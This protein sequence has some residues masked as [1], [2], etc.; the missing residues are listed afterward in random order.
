MPRLPA[1]GKRSARTVQLSNFSLREFNLAKRYLVGVSGGRD[2]VAL[3]HWLLE[4]GYRNLV[5]CHLNHQM[6]GRSSAADA[7]FVKQLAAKYDLDIEIG[8]ADVGTLAGKNKMSIET[9]A[10][11]ARFSFFAKVAKRKR[12]HTIF[13][14]HQAD[15]Q[16]E[17]FLMN[18]FRG[19]GTVGLGSMRE[20]TA[21]CID[22]VDLTI[23]RPLLSLW[24]KE[25]DAYLWTHHL[26]FREDASNRDLS[27]LRNRL[28]HRIIPYLEKTVG[29]NIRPSIWRTAMIMAEEENFFEELM[30][31]ELTELAVAEMRAMP[32]TMQRRTLREW[33]HSHEVPDVSFALI[34]RVR[35]LLDLMT[36]VAKT[37]LPGNRHA[38]RRAGK[39]FIE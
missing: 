37:N 22:E 5:I 33:L 21:R 38:R 14:A 29:R 10:R 13:L 3:L 28:R 34:E 17:T 4:R 24:R 27:A 31:R 36:G 39:I 7:R 9:A 8:S 26:K 30:P 12:C 16:V 11:F 32:V 15:D 6:R 2:S 35:A 20:V 25:V 19:A 23:V 1:A 18:L